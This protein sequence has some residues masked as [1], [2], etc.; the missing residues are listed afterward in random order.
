MLKVKAIF[1]LLFALAPVVARADL[2]RLTPP[3]IVFSSIE[4]ADYQNEARGKRNKLI[5][6]LAGGTVLALVATGITL[7]A[8]GL[9]DP[10]S[11]AMTSS[12]VACL[13]VATLGVF[14]G[15]ELIAW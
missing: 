2:P 5:M 3:P 13:S 6:S 11:S 4:I 15:L 1:V 7:M 12:G 10:G 9:G 14:T 8:I